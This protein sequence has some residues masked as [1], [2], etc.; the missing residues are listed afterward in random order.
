[1][2][3]PSTLNLDFTA[4]LTSTLM[5]QSESL[6]DNISAANYAFFRLKE[7]G[8]MNTTSDL[9]ER[10]KTNL[11]YALAPT[12]TYAG[13]DILPVD[14]VDGLTAAFWDWRNAVTPI[15]IS[16]DEKAKN[17]GSMVKVIDLLS[18]KTRQARQS[19]EEFWG[20][21]F[22]QGNGMN[23][24]TDIKTP[25]TDP[26]NGSVFIEPLASLVD[27]DPTA[28]RS[29]GNINQSTST[30][31]R[32]QTKD[33]ASTTYAGFRKVLRNAY[34]NAGKGGGGGKRFPDIHICDQATYEFY[35]E[36][37]TFFYRSTTPARADIPFDNVS[38]K[39]N[40]LTWDEN[41]PDVKNGTTTQSTTSGTWYML[42]SAFIG[43]TAD[44]ETNFRARPAV[45][46]A[47]QDAS[48][49]QILYRGASFV[50]NRRKHGV[51]GS[52]DTTIVS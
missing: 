36:M 15:S 32:N 18:T 17:R 6:A 20:K 41:I 25:Y 19:I 12:S 37:M 16:G 47:N 52:I 11:M 10:L 5:K 38:F 39:G 30:W 44:A 51:I 3:G 8:A 43:I 14:P 23:N 21:A 9:G 48:I 35:E 49:S 50:S 26:G 28:S 40:P 13:Y 33:D 7:V 27:F 34:N 46:P 1:M 29:I 22:I 2:A 42:N 4:L 45:E 31:W 24:P